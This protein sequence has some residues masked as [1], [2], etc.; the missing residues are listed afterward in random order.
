MPTTE[1]IAAPDASA[2]ADRLRDALSMLPAGCWPV[3]IE[4]I[5]GGSVDPAVGGLWRR[6]SVDLEIETF[7]PAPAGL[8]VGISTPVPAGSPCRIWWRSYRA[9]GAVKIGLLRIQV[10]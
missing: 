3:R 8:T 4:F 7:G 10:E 2:Y 9:G 6:G 1:P 5:D